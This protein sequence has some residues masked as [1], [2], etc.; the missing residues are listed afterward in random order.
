MLADLSLIAVLENVQNFI[1]TNKK[2]HRI[3][4]QKNLFYG[5]ETEF[6]KEDKFLAYISTAN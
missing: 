2:N 1:L 6:Q 4:E 3:L 5:N